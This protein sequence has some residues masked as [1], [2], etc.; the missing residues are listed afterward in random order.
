MSL[1]RFRS[2]NHPQQTRRRKADDTVDDRR[3]P[4]EIYDPLHRA[5]GFTLDVAAST[6]NAKTER[7]FSAEDDGLNK[8]WRSA[9]VW[10]NPPYS[11]CASWV[12]KAWEEMHYGCELVVMLLPANRTEQKWWQRAIEPHRDKAPVNGIR[13]TTR[14]LAGRPRFERPDWTPPKKG[15]RPPFGLVV[16][17]WERSA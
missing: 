14:F 2:Q 1:L 11:D 6:Q 12:E 13:L 9:R 3:T 5:Y 8:S 4:S 17:V 7:F 15:N 10:C 16:V